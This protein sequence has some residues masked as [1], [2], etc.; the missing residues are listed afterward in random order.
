MEL[1]LLFLNIENNDLAKISVYRQKSNNSFFKLT[2]HTRMTCLFSQ[3]TF[4]V[5]GISV[6]YFNN[7]MYYL[8]EDRYKHLPVILFITLTQ[9][10]VKIEIRCNT[11]IPVTFQEQNPWPLIFLKLPKALQ[12]LFLRSSTRLSV[13]AQRDTP[14]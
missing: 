2:I 8:M 9:Q 7:P 14:G 5:T 1:N 6:H 13:I 11:K 3:A 10:R 4:L 12:K